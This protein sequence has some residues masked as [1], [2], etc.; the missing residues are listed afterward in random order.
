IRRWR[1][2]DSRPTF[3]HDGKCLAWVGYDEQ[4]GIGRLWFVERDGAEP[5]AIGAPVNSFEAPCFT[6]DGKHL[7]V[8]T[9]GHAVQ[10]REIATGKELAPLDAHDSPVIG[11]AFTEDGRGVVSRG[12]T[13]ILS[14]DALTG[15]LAHRL[16]GFDGLEELEALLPDGRLFTGDRT[17]DP[18]QG[19]FRLRDAQT[20]RE[21]FRFEGRPDV[22]PPV[23]AVAPG[24]RFAAVHGRDGEVCVLL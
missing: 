6:P 13:G 8:V 12:R 20:E 2:G 5:R 7:A 4:R 1:R 10:L 23:V 17:T 14:W 24:G 16:N 11:V 19:L 21:T 22:G 18:R 3:S 9:D 15:R